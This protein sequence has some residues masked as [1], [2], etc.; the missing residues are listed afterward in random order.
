MFVDDAHDTQGNAEAPLG[1]IAT[2]DQNDDDRGSL[3]LCSFG[4]APFARGP[5]NTAQYYLI[6]MLHDDAALI[7]CLP[8]TI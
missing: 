6:S 2:E 8:Q 4:P 3:Y 7:I 5:F 1:W